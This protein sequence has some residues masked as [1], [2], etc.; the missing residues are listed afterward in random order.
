[1]PSQG[2]EAWSL[3]PYH[4]CSL[5]PTAGICFTYRT[6]NIELL[7]LYHAVAIPAIAQYMLLDDDMQSPAGGD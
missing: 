6:G 5:I 3:I 7:L 4:A 2:Y 1:M